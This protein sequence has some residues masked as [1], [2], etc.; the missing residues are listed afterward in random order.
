MDKILSK[1]Y[2]ITILALSLV[3]FIVVFS[4][5]Y[6]DK[7][8]EILT[9][10]NKFLT[11]ITSGKLTNDVKKDAQINI[12]PV[13]GDE[14]KIRVVISPDN[15]NKY[16]KL[17]ETDF[18][19]KYFYEDIRVDSKN[20]RTIV[21]KRA[22]IV[23]LDLK[24]EIV[25][26]IE[27]ATFDNKKMYLKIDESTEVFAPVYTIDKSSRKVVSMGVQQIIKNSLKD[28]LSGDVI[29][30]RGVLGK[31]EKDWAEIYAK[32]IVITYFSIP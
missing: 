29:V 1:N 31:Y 6:L 22:K 11:K 13:P 28:L 8:F 15:R 3:A 2:F 18:W 17:N 26:L 10:K 12:S 32:T 4:L 14:T 24:D 20:R 7:I 16:P 30:V 25:G 19:Q 9:S 23:T 5:L 27:S 21:T